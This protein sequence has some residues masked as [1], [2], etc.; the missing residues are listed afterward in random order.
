M[1]VM[2]KLVAVK[3]PQIVPMLDVSD[4]GRFG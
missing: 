4:A 1:A 2:R 3:V